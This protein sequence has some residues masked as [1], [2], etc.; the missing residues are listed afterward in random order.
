M[1]GKYAFGWS[2]PRG[3]FGGASVANNYRHIKDS[4]E[5]HFSNSMSDDELM[6]AWLVALGSG[7]ILF[8]KIRK[9]SDDIFFIGLNL[10]RRGLLLEEYSPNYWGERYT[11][12]NKLEKTNGNT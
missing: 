11:L 2:D 6:A 1:S 9:H 7:P 10:Y 8:E 12:V 5:G 3:L 4:V